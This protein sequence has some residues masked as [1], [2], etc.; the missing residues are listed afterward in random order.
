MIL[1]ITGTILLTGLLVFKNKSITTVPNLP[2]KK[3]EDFSHGVLALN[4]DKSD[5]LPGEKMMISMASLD[6]SGHTICNSNLKL[7]IVNSQNITTSIDINRS[8]TCGN[9]NVTNDPDYLASFQLGNSG[10]YLLEL[11]NYDTGK[12]V[13][14][15]IAVSESLPFNIQ[16]SGATRLNPFTSDRY[17]MIITITAN[18]DYQGEVTEK[19]PASFDIIWQGPASVKNSGGPDGQKI[20]TWNVNIKK[21]ETLVLRYEYNIPKVSPQFYTLGPVVIDSQA[22]NSFWQIVSNLK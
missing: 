19:V 18:N 3:Q 2:E 1:I 10:K 4:T 12:T 14:D 15:S 7:G 17:P 20:I 5:Y 22:F 21:N 9:E 8:P 11:T 13:T 6:A 16:R